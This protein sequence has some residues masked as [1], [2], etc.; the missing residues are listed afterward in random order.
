MNAPRSLADLRA[1]VDR[2]REQRVLVVGDLFLD[3]YI[4]TEM[5]EVSK[6]GP[7]PVLRFESSCRAAGASGNLASSIRKLGAKVELVAVAGNDAN[8]TYLLEALR[9][10]GIDADGVCVSDDT[11]TF[12]YSKIRARVEN[13]PSREILRLDVLPTEPLDTCREALLLETLRARIPE[14]DGVIVL[15]QIGHLLTDTILEEISRTTRA[16]GVHLQGSSRDRLELLRD[17]DLVIPNDRETVAALRALGALEDDD[18]VD[19]ASTEGSSVAH[20]GQTLLERS[21]HQR[22]L[23]TLGAE[24]MALFT[25]DPATRGRAARLPT[26]ASDVLD[27]TG[28]GDA[29]SSAALLATLAGEDLTSAAWLAACAAAVAIAEVGTHH[30]T[31]DELLGAAERHL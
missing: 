23:L 15:D 9:A 4:E 8:G 11:R 26:L 30:V 2:F 7:I 14:V 20:L 31:R 24:G 3:E 21:G 6:E 1:T 22:V 18:G 29:V 13:A 16:A 19:T 27:V 17:Y 10:D 12:T 25:R 28:A 5:Y